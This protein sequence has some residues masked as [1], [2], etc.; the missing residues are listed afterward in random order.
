MSERIPSR[1]DAPLA[2]PGKPRKRV[3]DP[4]A[5]MVRAASMAAE[6]EEARRANQPGST[7]ETIKRPAIVGEVTEDERERMEFRRKRE[8][9]TRGIQS[10]TLFYLRR[11]AADMQER[12]LADT[13]LHTVT[14]QAL[15]DAA[16]ATGTIE[17]P[18]EAEINRI[19]NGVRAFVTRDVP[20]A[21]DLDAVATR[22]IQLVEQEIPRLQTVDRT[23]Q[24]QKTARTKRAA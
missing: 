3:D 8:M 4:A 7:Y 6:L 19:Q 15:T 11:D 20:N 9:F 1:R 14:E 22:Y 2:M 21:E 5:R 18:D 10:L 12:S 17:T 13:S 16:T 24:Q 23:T